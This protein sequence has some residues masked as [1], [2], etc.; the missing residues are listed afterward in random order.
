MSVEQNLTAR[1]RFKV[2]KIRFSKKWLTIILYEK[3]AIKYS[4]FCGDNVAW[5]VFVCLF[6]QDG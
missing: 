3:I 4:V 5:V 2:L 1:F 6:F